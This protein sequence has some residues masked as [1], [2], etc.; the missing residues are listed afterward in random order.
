MADYGD[1]GEYEYEWPDEE[2]GAGEGWPDEDG[3]GGEDGPWVQIENSFYE[4]EGNFK[5]SPEEAL[6]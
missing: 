2:D 1:E 4:A 3:D 5:D 6:Q